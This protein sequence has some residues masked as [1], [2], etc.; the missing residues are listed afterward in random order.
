MKIAQSKGIDV[1]YAKLED[2]PYQDGVFDMVMATDVLEHVLDLH[3]ATTQMLRVLKP[4]GHLI[5][6]VPYREDLEVYLRT[7]LPYEFIHLRNFDEHSLR[8]H[9]QKI[10]RCEVLEINPVAPF[11][12]GAQRLRYRHFS[13]ADPIHA[14]FKRERF[15]L[16]RKDPIAYLV[17][18]YLRALR[19]E[20]LVGWLYRLQRKKPDSFAAIKPHL[21]MGIEMNVVV[22]KPE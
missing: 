13:K 2:M 6:R 21:L 7:D 17:I 10:F 14:W 9:F 20:W 1:A 11:L 15:N 5:I 4:G 22:R 16:L 12:Q 8:L 18:E 3:A 19:E